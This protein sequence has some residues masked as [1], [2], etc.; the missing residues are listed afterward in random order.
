MTFNLR[1]QDEVIWDDNLILKI[2]QRHLQ[3]KNVVKW[4]FEVEIF[5]K[6]EESLTFVVVTSNLL[7]KPKST[8]NFV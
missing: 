1:T 2:V 5:V 6:Y 7:R 3:L 4:N 8:V